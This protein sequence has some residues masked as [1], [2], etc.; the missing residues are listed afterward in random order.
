MDRQEIRKKL[1]E[2]GL[3]DPQFEH[4]SCGVGFIVHMKGKKSHDIIEKALLTLHHLEH[5]GACGCEVNTGD[6]AGILI[7]LPHAFL[8]K[9]FGQVGIQLP[10]EGKYGVG[11]LFLPQ[12]PE[13]QKKAEQILEHVVAEEGQKFLGWRPVPVDASM[14]G[15]MSK[16]AMPLM[17]QFAIGI[18]DKG[19]NL[20]GPADDA[21]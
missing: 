2:N 5:R 16:S 8:T 21:W 13:Q 11:T 18:G 14:L 12:D 4:D 20:P 9:V 19:P 7:Q 15:N 17:K 3:Y 1:E 10:E 6:G